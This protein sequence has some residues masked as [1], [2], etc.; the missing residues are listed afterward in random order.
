MNQSMTEQQTGNDKEELKKIDSRQ[1]KIR[2]S[3]PKIVGSE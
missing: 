1:K 3:A 2:L